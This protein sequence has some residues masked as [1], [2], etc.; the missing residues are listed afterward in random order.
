M[1]TRRTFLCGLMLGTL[2]APLAAEGQ[3]AGK[4]YRIGVLSSASSA[5]MQPQ[6]DAFREK[7]RDLGYEEG[8]NIAIEYRWAEGRKYD[9]LPNLAAELMTSA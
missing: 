4:V 7:L 2:A 6:L 3:Q 8:K 5:M 1:I 9:R